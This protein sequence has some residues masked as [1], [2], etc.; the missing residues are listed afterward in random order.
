MAGLPLS[1]TE[2]ASSLSVLTGLGIGC[3][4]TN[5]GVLV[6]FADSEIEQKDSV[7]IQIELKGLRRHQ[8]SLVY[9]KSAGLLRQQIKNANRSQ[10]EISNKLADTVFRDV[11]IRLDVEELFANICANSPSTSALL[12]RVN[13][14]DHG[15]EGEWR[16]SLNRVVTPLLL[17]LAELIGFEDDLEA[18]GEG[19]GD[20]EGAEYLRQSVARERSS[21][22]RQRCITLRGATCEVCGWDSKKVYGLDFEIID[23]HHTEPLSSFEGSKVFNPLTD[24]VP[25]CPNCHRAA[26]KKSPPYSVEELKMFVNGSSA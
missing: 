5:S 24:L 17:A 15:S 12:S 26:H 9:G 4:Q 2:I 18:I 1:V 8:F 3:S 13:I 23:V 19:Q 25:L 16:K 14:E 7:G 20:S 10:V 6:F 22:N 11:D 21:R